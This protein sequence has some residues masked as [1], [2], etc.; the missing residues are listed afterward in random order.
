MEKSRNFVEL[1]F[2][3]GY[4]E[5]GFKIYINY[6]AA[7]VDSLD[8]V[9]MATKLPPGCLAVSKSICTQ[10]LYSGSIWKKILLPELT[11]HNKYLCIGINFIFIFHFNF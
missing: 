9:N 3:C 5:L 7:Y 10:L 2:L 8:W 11:A 6:I 1:S 4:F